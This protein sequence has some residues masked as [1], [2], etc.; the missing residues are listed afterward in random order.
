MPC[1]LHPQAFLLPQ[2]CSLRIAAVWRSKVGGFLMNILGDRMMQHKMQV[3]LI[4]VPL[5]GLIMRFVTWDVAR[6]ALITWVCMH[7]EGDTAH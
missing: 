7:A 2:V 3:A 5:L 4:A 6:I 1:V